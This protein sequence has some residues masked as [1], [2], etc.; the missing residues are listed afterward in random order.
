MVAAAARVLAQHPSASL[1]DIAAVI[2][3]GRTT[4]HRMFPTRRDL[5]VAVAHDAIDHLAVIYRKAGL[6]SE[7]ADGPE[8]LGALERV[9]KEMIPLGA[10]LLFLLRSSELADD[11]TLDARIT[12]LDRPLHGAIAAGQRLDAISADLPAWWAFDMLM[13]SVY[14]AWEQI[15]AGRLAPLDAPAL[16]MRTWVR[17]VGA[18]PAR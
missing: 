8:V 16:V 4:L 10:S 9:V 12:A 15:E 7:F 14:V 18:T 17:G 13:A 11:G 5:L 2:G 3:I 1:G 6:G